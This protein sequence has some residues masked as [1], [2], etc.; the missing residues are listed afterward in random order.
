MKTAMCSARRM[1][2]FINTFLK[3]NGIIHLKTDQTEI[4][5]YT[6][7]QILKFEHELLEEYNDLYVQRLIPDPTRPLTLLTPDEERQRGV[8]TKKTSCKLKHNLN[9][10]GQNVGKRLN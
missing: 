7:K 9:K 1:R 10:Y 4:Y 6:M 2:I 8:N 3:P 5:E